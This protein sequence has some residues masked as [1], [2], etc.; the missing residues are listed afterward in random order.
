M[1]QSGLAPLRNTHSRL[2]I[3]VH[4][5]QVAM[6]PGCH[7]RYY[8]GPVIKLAELGTKGHDCEYRMFNLNQES[9]EGCSCD[10]GRHVS[11]RWPESTKMCIGSWTHKEQSTGRPTAT[12]KM[13]ARCPV[14]RLAKPP[15][16][17][18]QQDPTQSTGT[19]ARPRPPP[20]AR[21]SPE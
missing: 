19:Q 15:H 18:A 11:P 20:L 9:G 8:E 6:G 21:R 5:G 16:R 10:S 7:H 1:A 2:K 13:S 12:S 17:R 4:G 3:T 14:T